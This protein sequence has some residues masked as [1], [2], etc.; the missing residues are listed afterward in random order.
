[1]DDKTKPSGSG[2]LREKIMCVALAKKCDRIEDRIHKEFTHA[3]FR[4]EKVL[5][6]YVN[7]AIKLSALTKLTEEQRKIG[8]ARNVLRESVDII[9]HT[10]AQFEEMWTL[11]G[12]AMNVSKVNNGWLEN[13]TIYDRHLADIRMALE[14]MLIFS[15]DREIM[16]TVRRMVNQ[17]SDIQIKLNALTS[18]VQE[19]T[20]EQM[21]QSSSQL[22]EFVSKKLG[23]NSKSPRD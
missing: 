15:A 22:D 17:V 16:E 13:T 12:K 11:M 23:E 19:A 9:K 5:Y 3:L 8:D 18:R 7:V 4:W 1:M 10:A 14:P 20:G 2:E 6:D 21:R